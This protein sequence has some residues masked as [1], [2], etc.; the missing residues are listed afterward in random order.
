MFAP[1]IYTQVAT[2]TES[3]NLPPLNAVPDFTA[4]LIYG[5]TGHNHLAELQGCLDG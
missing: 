3:I 5:L 4:G 2:T 1:S